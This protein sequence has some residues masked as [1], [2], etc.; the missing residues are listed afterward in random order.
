MSHATTSTR[1]VKPTI[2]SLPAVLQ[3]IQ[4][5]GNLQNFPASRQ[6]RMALLKAALEHELIYWNSAHGKF[7]LTQVGCKRTDKLPPDRSSPPDL[8]AMRKMTVSFGDQRP[9]RD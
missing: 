5:R 2:D 4:E 7:E 6:R 3:F 8:G 1:M 9:L